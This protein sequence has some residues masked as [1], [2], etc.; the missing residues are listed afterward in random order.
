MILIFEIPHILT[1]NLYSCFSLQEAG[2][3]RRILVVARLVASLV[4]GISHLQ[5]GLLWELEV[6]R[7]LLP[8]LTPHSLRATSL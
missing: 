7:L 5:R 2:A 1:N 4:L 6:L 3:R 8:A